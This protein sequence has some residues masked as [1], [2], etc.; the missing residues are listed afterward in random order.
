VIAEQFNRDPVVISQGITALEQKVRGDRG[1][2]RMVKRIEEFLIQDK[3]QK[4]V[5]GCARLYALSFYF[6]P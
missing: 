4:Y 3:K 6:I 5:F 1:F 2:R